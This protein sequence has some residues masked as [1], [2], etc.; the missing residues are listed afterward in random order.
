MRALDK[1][2][3]PNTDNLMQPIHME[4]YQKLKTFCD[5]S[6]W[7]FRLNFGHLPKKDDPHSLFISKATACQKHG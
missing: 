5:F 1:C 2:S 3:V 4:L 7:K 6:F